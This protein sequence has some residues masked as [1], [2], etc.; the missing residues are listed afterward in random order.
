MSENKKRSKFGKTIIVCAVAV[1]LGM[2]LTFIGPI[3]AGMD[4]YNNHDHMYWSH[5][6]SAYSSEYCSYCC[7][8]NAFSYAMEDYD[9]YLWLAI[10]VGGSLAVVGAVMGIISAVRKSKKTQ[11][12]AP[13]IEQIAPTAAVSIPTGEG[14]K[15]VLERGMFFNLFR[16]TVTTKRVLYK[17]IF[18][19]RMSLPLNRISATGTG[20]FGFLHIG[21]SAG[22]IFM[23]LFRHYREVYETIG[24]LLSQVQ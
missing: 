10:F 1:V 12:T 5:Y 14:E 23:V 21:S 8:D 18:W 13:Q 17:G 11:T 20:I 4:R 6:D 7:Y 22:H 3:S 9:G 19:R 2:L 15:V 16:I 24:A